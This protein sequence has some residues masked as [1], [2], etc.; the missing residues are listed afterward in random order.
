MPHLSTALFYPRSGNP[1]ALVI[2]DNPMAV[3]NYP[4]AKGSFTQ[5][6]NYF[7]K[8]RPYQAPYAYEK[9]QNVPNSTTALNKNGGASIL[10]KTN[11]TAISVL[12]IGNNQKAEPI[13]QSIAQQLEKPLKINPD[14]PENSEK[15]ELNIRRPSNPCQVAF[16]INWDN[17]AN[18]V[19]LFVYRGTQFVCGRNGNR[20]NPAIGDWD[21]GKSRNRLI[22]NDL[23]TNQEAVRQFKNIVA[24]EY[25][26]FAQ[27]KETTKP[28]SIS[29]VRLNGLIYTKNE[30]GVE[31]STTFNTVVSLNPKVKQVIG[32][33][34]IQPDGTFFFNKL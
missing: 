26:I 15:G 6:G 17:A 32:S 23:R 33:V 7:T 34:T 8:S 9:G 13:L 12:P 4:L 14:L 3:I 1:M 18:N 22:N 24:G 19:D 5:S 31:K 25:R 29:S 27:F 28:D 2:N 21:S 30:K 10:E 11:E 16:E 20:S